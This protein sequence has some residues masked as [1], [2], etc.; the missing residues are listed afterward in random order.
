MKTQEQVA[1]VEIDKLGSI[2]MF[3]FMNKKALGWV[4]EN[5]NYESWQWAGGALAVDAR[6]GENLEGQMKEAGLLLK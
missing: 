2:W 6:M 1:D 4:E 5:V 3:A